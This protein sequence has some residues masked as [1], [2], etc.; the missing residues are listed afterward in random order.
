[1]WRAAS[2]AAL[3]KYRL[4]TLAWALYAQTLPTKPQT[5]SWRGAKCCGM[6][7][8]C[9]TGGEQIIKMQRLVFLIFSLAFVINTGCWFK[10]YWMWI[11][12]LQF[13]SPHRDLFVYIKKNTIHTLYTTILYTHYSNFFI[14]CAYSNTYIT[15]FSVITAVTANKSA[16]SSF[17]LYR[18]D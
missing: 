10:K 12:K 3:C 8:G 4:H 17:V 13:Y 1:M 18:W 5:C 16:L 7:A 14:C 9:A 6:L 11:W 2:A 15:D